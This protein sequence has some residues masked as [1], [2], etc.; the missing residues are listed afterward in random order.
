MLEHHLDRGTEQDDGIE[1]VM[2]PP[3]VGTQPATT[4]SQ[5]RTDTSGTSSA[6]N[7]SIRGSTRSCSQPAIRGR[8]LRAAYRDRAAVSRYNSRNGSLATTLAT[9]ASRPTR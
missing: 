4:R 5:P 2:N 1:P 8:D 3:L 7:A 9:S 6:S